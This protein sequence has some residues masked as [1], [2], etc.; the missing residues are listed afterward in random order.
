MQCWWAWLSRGV[1]CHFFT[2]QGAESKVFFLL[3]RNYRRIRF[4]GII[5]NVIGIIG[6]SRILDNGLLFR[7]LV[8]LHL[9]PLAFACK[10]WCTSYIF[11]SF[12]VPAF[13]ETILWDWVH[14]QAYSQILPSATRR[15]YVSCSMNSSV[16]R[17]PW[18]GIMF[19]GWQWLLFAYDPSGNVI[20]F[21]WK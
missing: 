2:K 15:F 13:M 11:I 4:A 6:I 9:S 17:I 16:P 12:C 3:F 19:P 7:P 1:E 14:V 18:L 21:C 10:W 5:G 20:R 8:R